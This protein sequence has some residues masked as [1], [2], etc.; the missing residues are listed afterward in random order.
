MLIMHLKK[1]KL[2]LEQKEEQI[3]VQEQTIDS[4]ETEI[5]NIESIPTKA[6]IEAQKRERENLAR[7]KVKE[8]E[9]VIKTINEV[10]G[11]HQETEQEL[12]TKGV[13]VRND[14]GVLQF[15]INKETSALLE[16]ESPEILEAFTSGFKKI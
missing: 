5:K 16:S 7:V 6:L 4:I 12:I 1:T 3:S 10:K 2:K 13:L 15:N 11:I 9:Q 8:F 14:Q